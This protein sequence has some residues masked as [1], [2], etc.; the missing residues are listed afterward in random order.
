[1]KNW[2]PMRYY[3]AAVGKR[4]YYGRATGDILKAQMALAE[5]RRMYPGEE[6]GIAAYA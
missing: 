4:Y 1:M 3:V 5:A 6:W 2:R